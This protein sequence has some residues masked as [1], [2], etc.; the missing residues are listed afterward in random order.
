MSCGC[1]RVGMQ[2][3][4]RWSVSDIRLEG[5]VSQN[6]WVFLCSAWSLP[7][8]SKLSQPIYSVEHW[9]PTPI[10]RYLIASLLTGDFTSQVPGGGRI[11]A[12]TP[13]DPF[14]ASPVSPLVGAG[15]VDP[16]RRVVQKYPIPKIRGT[17]VPWRSTSFK[18]SLVDAM[19]L[20]RVYCRP[21]TD[22]L[23]MLTFAAP[24][25]QNV[26]LLNRYRSHDA[27]CCYNKQIGLLTNMMCSWESTG[28][29][30]Q[31]TS[32]PF[33][34]FF[35][36]ASTTE[37][38]WLGVFQLFQ[39]LHESLEA[40]FLYLETTCKDRESRCWCYSCASF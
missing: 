8:Y 16:F 17:L 24:N 35:A 30:I 29:Y 14:G 7:W 25:Q 20:S 6:V 3:S 19:E 13:L 27:W 5:V 32:L 9:N 33:P 28:P 38:K 11:S 23:K 2:E 31:P 15:C 34:R 1:E 40:L 37:D 26:R 21:R 36:F 18:R 39:Y 4:P 10:N 12:I 22:C